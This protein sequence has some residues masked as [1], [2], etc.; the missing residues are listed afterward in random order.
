L[1]RSATEYRKV[2]ALLHTD[3]K[4]LWSPHPRYRL[5]TTAASYAPQLKPDIDA[6][7]RFEDEICRR[8]EVAA[9]VCVPMARTGLFLTLSETIPLGRKVIM[10]PLTIV[11]AVNAVLLAGCVPVFADICRTSCSLDP[12]EAEA[13]IDHETS[14]ILITHLHGETAG[15]HRFRE[16][17]NRRGVLLI[18]DAAQAFGAIEAGQRLGTIGDAGIYSFGFFKNLSTWRGGMVVS[19]D[20]AL[21]ERIRNRV[22]KFSPV[23][24]RDLLMTLAAGLM[25][26]VGTWPPVFSRLAY[27]LVRRNPSWMARWLDPE[28]G[29]SRLDVLPENYFGRTRPYQ[30]SLGLRRL[31]HVDRDT[32]V[33]I[34][35]ARH[36]HDK[37]DSLREIIK[38]RRS[39]DFSNIY[40]YFPVQMRNRPAV[41]D[42]ARRRGR[43]FAAQHLRNCADLD[44]FRE[45]YRE[46]PNARLASQELI[47]LPTYPRYPA[48]EVQRNIEVIEEFMNH[49]G[50]NEDA[51]LCGSGYDYGT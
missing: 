48:A 6:I 8:F 35:H 47:L 33:R 4:T 37:L 22:R 7:N 16:V 2:E 30:A 1:L 34:D 27:P 49:K 19:N 20:R 29:A 40:T 41:L 45:L 50:A 15:A 21:I 42:Y 18:E 31:D 46:C 23:F 24:K 43:D 13:L 44:E 10:S 12:E 51:R 17:C 11:D 36:Y 26:D 38:P 3:R 28:A 5:Y 32:S 14:A 39:E 9:A 25:V